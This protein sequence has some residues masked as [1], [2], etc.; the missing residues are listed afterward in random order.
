[1][2]IIT[3]CVLHIH[4]SRFLNTCIVKAFDNFRY[5]NELLNG[6]LSNTPGV[7]YNLYNGRVRKVRCMCTVIGLY[8]YSVQI[9][10]I[11]FII[12]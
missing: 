4:Q 8:V 1:M 7:V 2:S 10:G 6:D 9:V 3:K 12:Y 11:L 5:L